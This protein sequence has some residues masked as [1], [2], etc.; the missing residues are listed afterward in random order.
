MFF[1]AQL[2]HVVCENVTMRK[3]GLVTYLS[4]L[5]MFCRL[6]FQEKEVD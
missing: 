2:F 6:I 1:D 5:K 4:E 3:C